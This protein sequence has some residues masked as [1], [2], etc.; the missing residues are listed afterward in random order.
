VTR[1]YVPAD[2]R[3]PMAAARSGAALWIACIAGREPAEALD[4]RDREDLVAELVGR[5]WSDVEIAVLARMS[6]YT[7][8]RIRS[9]LGLAANRSTVEAAA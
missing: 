2:V 9:R 4:A 7:T 6:T 3:R 5:G 8:A 1:R